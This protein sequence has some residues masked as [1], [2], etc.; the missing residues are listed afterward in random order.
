MITI[1]NFKPHQ[2]GALRGFLDVALASGMS[3]RGLVLFEKDGNRWTK[4]PPRRWLD[5]Q[6]EWHE[7]PIIAIEDRDRKQAFDTAVLAALD[8]YTGEVR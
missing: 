5:K 6:G 8:Q 1:N 4:F 3:I 7:E 2:S